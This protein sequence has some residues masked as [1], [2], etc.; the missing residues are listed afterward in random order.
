MGERSDRFLELSGL[1]T[2]FGRVQLA[3]TGMTETYLQALD[4]VLPAG[5]IDELLAA[6]QRLPAGP[7]REAAAASQILG[8]PKLGPVARNVIVLWYCGTWTALPDA[9]RAAYGA[10]PQDTTHVVSGE[11]YQAGLQWT[12]AG[13]HPPGASPQGFGAW[14]LAPGEIRR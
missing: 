12:A 5:V 8:D 2:G 4:A 13:A 10:S 9:W 11:A 1:L 14:A 7:G 6:F 3:G